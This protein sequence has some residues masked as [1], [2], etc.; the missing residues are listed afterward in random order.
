MVEQTIGEWVSYNQ[1]QIKYIK[2]QEILN[3]LS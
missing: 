3:S 1:V 2:D